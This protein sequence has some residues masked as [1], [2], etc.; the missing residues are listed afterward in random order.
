M[1]G[2]LFPFFFAFFLTSACAQGLISPD[3]KAYNAANGIFEAPR[4]IQ[5]LEAFIAEYPSSP[6]VVMARKAIIDTAL[7]NWPDQTT[8]LR[9]QARSL[10]EKAALKDRSSISLIIANRYVDAGVLPNDAARLASNALKGASDDRERAEALELIGRIAIH[11]GKDSQ[12]EKA[13]SEALRLNPELRSAGIALG[14]LHFRRKHYIQAVEALASAKVNGK[15]VKRSQDH[16]EAAWKATH[17]SL[18]GL[19]EM[20]DRTYRSR[21]PNPIRVVPYRPTQMR[22]SRVVLAEVFTSASCGPCAAVDLAF[23]AALERYQ[24]KDV[25]IV[26]YH[27]HIPQPDPLTAPSNKFRGRFYG[28]EGTP[29]WAIDGRVEGNGGPRSVANFAW[30][31]IEPVIDT[32][33]EKVPAGELAISS[34]RQGSVVRTQIRASAA[35]QAKL[36]IVLVERME[37]YSGENGIRFHPMVARE[38]RELAPDTIQVTFDLEQIASNL[39]NYLNRY[40]ADG[41]KGEP[42]EFSEKKWQIDPGNLAVV[43][44]LQTPEDKKVLQ[45]VYEEIR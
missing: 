30:Q 11:R 39:K 12:A 15:L 40:E 31:R 21:Y 18:N 16:L 7:R 41:H 25:A 5:A 44:F 1:L 9:I 45:A 36:H 10:I 3:R 23:E 32:A 14:D 38:H 13:L 42:F 4:K 34:I 37:R 28:V 29:L 6:G 43:A 2:R 26:M 33:L 8:R 22:T 35:S 17:G 20:L 27:M 24:R 19:E